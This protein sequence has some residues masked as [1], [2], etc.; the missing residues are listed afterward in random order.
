MM[1]DCFLG[2]LFTSTSFI[3]SLAFKD[4]EIYQ[5]LHFRGGEGD[6]RRRVR[7]PSQRCFSAVVF[8]YQRELNRS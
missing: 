2:R 6:G 8:P 5:S 7:N 1:N 4:A 3:F